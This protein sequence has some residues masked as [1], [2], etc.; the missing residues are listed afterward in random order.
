MF[1][2]YCSMNVLKILARSGA[3]DV[4]LCLYTEDKR[5]KEIKEK[6]PRDATRRARII[7]LED[8]GLVE[9]KPVKHGRNFITYYSLTDKGKEIFE[10]LKEIKDLI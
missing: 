2:L 4:L 10:K 7:E 6:V 9:R 5:D 3:M 1:L 8:L